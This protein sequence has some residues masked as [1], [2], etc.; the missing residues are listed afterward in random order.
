MT[1]GSFEFPQCNLILNLRG[2]SAASNL[3]R[4]AIGEDAAALETH[5]FLRKLMRE[6]ELKHR[7]SSH[8]SEES[9]Q[10]YG[11]ERSGD[12]E[13]RP[14]G[15]NSMAESEQFPTGSGGKLMTKA[16]LQAQ[17]LLDSEASR[18]V[19]EVGD[20]A[21]AESVGED[22]AFSAQR[23]REACLARMDRTRRFLMEQ[24]RSC[25]KFR[26][27]NILLKCQV[28]ISPSRLPRHRTLRQTPRQPQ[29][30]DVHP[31]G[32]SSRRPPSPQPQPPS[33]PKAAGD[34]ER[35]VRWADGTDSPGGGLAAPRDSDHDW[36]SSSAASH[37]TP[38][39]AAAAAQGALGRGPGRRF[40]TDPGPDFEPGVFCDGIYD[41]RSA[42][43]RPGPGDDG[44][45]AGGGSGGGGGDWA[46]SRRARDG[47][48]AAERPTSAAAA[49]APCATGPRSLGIIGTT[50]VWYYYFY[51]YYY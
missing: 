9:D 3:F 14:G 51:H 30:R 42:G 2:G 41:F 47:E 8:D 49:A 50:I 10:N 32:G 24:V 35:R 40:S 19:S 22:E 21:A 37:S 1:P 6:S 15:P 46:G 18:A 27:R 26:E 12:S 38:A 23:F 48:G 16:E 4:S 20:A 11:D 7:Q 45:S 5:G 36:D 17:N 33:P 39:G 25:A 34:S 29:R 31:H 13:S 28:Q 44:D 43:A